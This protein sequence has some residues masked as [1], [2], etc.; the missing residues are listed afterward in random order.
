[1]ALQAQWAMCQGN[2]AQL[3]FKKLATELALDDERAANSRKAFEG[4]EE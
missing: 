4:C 3:D 2:I 1:M